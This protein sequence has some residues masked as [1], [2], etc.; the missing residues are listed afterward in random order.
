MLFL[1]HECFHTNKCVWKDPKWGRNVINKNKFLFIKLFI[2]V[3]FYSG[4]ITEEV[5]KQK[6]DNFVIELENAVPFYNYYFTVFLINNCS[7]RVLQEL[8]NYLLYFP[9]SFW[10]FLSIPLRPR[11]VI[12]VAGIDP[13]PNEKNNSYQFKGKRKW[14]ESFCCAR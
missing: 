6:Y 3:I 2:L 7:S 11:K 13:F 4:K 8:Q 5:C 12:N 9:K 14:N 1:R 10:P